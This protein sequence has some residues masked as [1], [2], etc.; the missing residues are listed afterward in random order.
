MNELLDQGYQIIRG[1]MSQDDLASVR[2]ALNESIDRAAGAMRAPFEWSCPHIP[3][4]DRLDA[5][6]RQDRTYALALFRVALADSHRDDRLAAIASHVRLGMV[7]EDLLS[8]LKRTGHTIRPRAAVS[9][10][11]FARSPWHQDVIR[12]YNSTTGCGSVRLACWIPLMDVDENTGALEVIPGPWPEPLPHHPS[13]EGHVFIAEEDLPMSKRRSVPL[14]QGDV[15]VIDRFL[16][17]RSLP[18]HDGRSRW[19]VVMWVKACR[20]SEEIN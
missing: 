20:S 17:H 13:H 16:P 10:L 12:D 2:A 6:A 15:L 19:A 3:L 18:T 9:A 1:V 8:P 5:I 14:K 11:S 7:V 4:E